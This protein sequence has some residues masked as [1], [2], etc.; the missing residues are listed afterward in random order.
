MKYGRRFYSLAK[1]VYKAEPFLYPSL[2]LERAF[3]LPL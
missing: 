1:E 3:R 2:R